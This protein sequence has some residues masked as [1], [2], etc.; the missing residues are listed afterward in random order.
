L[1]LNHVRDATRLTSFVIADY[2]GLDNAY[3]MLRYA[4][5]VKT[6]RKLLFLRYFSP[7]KFASQD[8]GQVCGVCDN[9]CLDPPVEQD[10][11]REA[12]DLARLVK[13]AVETEQACGRST[14][15]KMAELW[16][17]KHG[18]HLGVKQAI[19]DGYVQQLGQHW[20]LDVSCIMNRCSALA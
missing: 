3:A 12:H 6:C 7:E 11:T 5:D 9:C 16:H 15:L 19:A 18:K 4:N 17:G 14:F 8:V 10:V 20:T 13:V 1:L 2:N